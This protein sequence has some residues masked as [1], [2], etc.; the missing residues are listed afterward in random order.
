VGLRSQTEYLSGGDWIQN[1]SQY[2]SFD[3]FG[4]SLDVAYRSENGQRPNSDLEQTTLSF[5]GKFDVTDK[6][7][8]LLLI[9]RYDYES[10]DVAAYYDPNDAQAD[11][12]VQEVQEPLIAAGWHHRWSPEHSSI[13]LFNYTYDTLSVAASAQPVL[14][15]G[16]NVAQQV[17]LVPVPNLPTAPLDYDSSFRLFGGELQHLW[18]NERNTLIAGGRYQTGTF[19]TTSTL[20][21][22]T[23]TQLGQGNPPTVVPGFYG[24]PALVQTEQTT[25]DRYGAYAYYHLHVWEPL[26]LVGGVAYE[27]VEYPL[28]HRNSP[29]ASGETSANQWSPK[30]GFI[31]EPI[32]G[33][34]FRGAYSK[35]LGGVSLD[36]SIRIEPVQVVGFN[37]AFRSLIPESVVGAAAAPSFELFGLAWDQ[38]FSKTGTYFGVSAE[39]LRSS[40]QR[41][42]GNFSLLTAFPFPITPDTIPQ[43][44]DFEERNLGIALNQ[45]VGRDWVFNVG[46]RISEASLDTQ[47]PTIPSTVSSAS[48]MHQSALLHE[49]NLGAVFNHPSGFFSS[50]EAFWLS[51][52]NRGYSPDLP[53]DTF[54]HV[55]LYAGYRF[56]RRRAEVSVGVLN[57]TD[58]DYR[59]NPLN[60][61]TGLRRDRTFVA[62]L[63]FQF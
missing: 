44:L 33:T 45:L 36:Q 7:R 39:L 55:N 57:L 56:F 4:Y 46:Y 28:N 35:F 5:T 31:Y 20:G 34:V 16:Q 3:G 1:A 60:L 17:T 13:A 19:D 42:L 50:A 54:W 26:Q 62:G 10:G 15:L 52:S 51:Q 63:K 12:R 8:L 9:S 27:F 61:H 38:R 24:S 48:E 37:Q 21:A 30:A 29:V 58:Q 2:G 6:D 22:S 43:N 59:L 53:G 47:F 40:V 23:T 18:Q 32:A 49:V 11:L 14:L 25:M 41:E